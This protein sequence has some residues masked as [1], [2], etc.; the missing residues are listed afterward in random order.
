MQDLIYTLFLHLYYDA[1]RIFLRFALLFCI[2]RRTA[3][4]VT[5]DDDDRR[6]FPLHH[7]PAAGPAAV[8]DLLLHSR[9]PRAKARVTSRMPARS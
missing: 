3:L 4:A 5:R 9:S 2:D 8:N 1:K 6:S 7:V